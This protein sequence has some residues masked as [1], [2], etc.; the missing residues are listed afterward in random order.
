MNYWP[1]HQEGDPGTTPHEAANPPETVMPYGSKVR[2]WRADAGGIHHVRY[3]VTHHVRHHVRH[4][5]PARSA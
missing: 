4:H 1:S 5:G 3:H 2:L